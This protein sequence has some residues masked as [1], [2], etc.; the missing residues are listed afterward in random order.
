MPAHSDADTVRLIREAARLDRTSRALDV[1]CGPGLV[2]FALGEIAQHVA[3]S[4]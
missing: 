3:P 4:C 1:A 2:A